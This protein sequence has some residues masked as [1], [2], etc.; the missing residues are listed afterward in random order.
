MV[1]RGYIFIPTCYAGPIGKFEPQKLERGEIDLA[2]LVEESMGMDA[3]ESFRRFHHLLP[4]L[5]SVIGH[6]T[7]N[8]LIPIAEPQLIDGNT[9]TQHL[10]I[11][12]RAARCTPPGI[13]ANIIESAA[14]AI[15][16]IYSEQ[17][18]EEK[19]RR[20]GLAARRLFDS[21]AEMDV[22]DAF[23]DLWEA[24]E[25][26]CP[27]PSRP[28]RYK[29]SD[30]IALAISDYTGFHLPQIRSSLID[31]AYDIRK[32]IVHEA[33]E[34]E[35]KVR[36]MVPVLEEVVSLLIRS[37]LGLPFDGSRTLQTFLH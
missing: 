12:V 37:R 30:R 3:K 25:F 2:I 21:K 14:R 23:C 33:I 36:S 20:I 9:S 35:S 24:C 32:D 10:G 5:A 26:L 29:I 6:T 17:E 4:A 22:I 15:A 13:L 11:E 31:V 34:D 8:L 16:E 27:R 28:P 19:I 18:G 1:S 7:D